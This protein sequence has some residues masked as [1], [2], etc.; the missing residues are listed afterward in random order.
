MTR[1]G[2]LDALRALAIAGVVLVHTAQQLPGLGHGFLPSVSGLGRF[3]VQLFFVISGFLLGHLYAGQAETW[4]PRIYA[5][6]RIG[7]IYP[8]YFVFA[9]LWMLAVFV[10]LVQLP[11]QFFN[12]FVILTTFLLLNDLWW[13]SAWGFLPG[14]WSISAEAVHY[15][16]F[17]FI[18][19]QARRSLLV[20]LAITTAVSTLAGVW[21]FLQTSGNYSGQ[22]GAFY[23]WVNT[24]APWNTVPYFVLGLLISSY[25]TPSMQASSKAKA[26]A[27]FALLVVGVTFTQLIG[28]LTPVTLAWIAAVFLLIMRSSWNPPEWITWVGRRSYATYFTHFVVLALFAEAAIRLEWDVA[29][30]NPTIALAGAATLV[31]IV[32]TLLSQVLWVIVEGPFIRLTHRQ[33]TV[34]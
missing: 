4:N 7:R 13:T 23:S 15:A 26:T 18:R 17:P 11:G 27:L 3:G 29:G 2:R 5:K 10:G 21:S 9:I 24:F 16:I 19:T 6:R 8:L 33:V 25:L 34:Q 28:S 12:A 31:L 22:T 14:A 30:I 1:N 32:S 20:L